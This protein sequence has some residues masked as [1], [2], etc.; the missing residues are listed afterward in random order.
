[1]ILNDFLKSVR[2]LGDSAFL[3]VLALG[4]GLTAALL[5]GFY[6]GFVG[7]IGWFVPDQLSLPWIGEITWVDNALSWAAIPLMLVLSALLMIPVASAFTGLFLDRIAAAVEQRHYPQLPPGR[8]I[9]V[10]EGLGDGLKFLAILIGANILALLLYLL[11]APA[12]PLIFWGLNGFLLGREYAQMV[13]LRRLDA[14]G[15]RA[16]RRRH[17]GTIF[18]AGVLM[19]VPLTIPV[20][21]LLVPVLGAATFT[22]L[23][24]RLT[25]GSSPARNR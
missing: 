20:V 22:H 25:P 10:L 11:F 4:L 16:F 24:H 23:Y 15:A 18:A 21:N 13:A 5:L 8:D 7:L 12:A 3:G 1:M 17:S 19:A 9:G 14:A 2:Q 6:L